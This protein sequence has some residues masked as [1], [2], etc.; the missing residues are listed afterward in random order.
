[1]AILAGEICFLV[2]GRGPLEY[3]CDMTPGAH[4]GF[5]EAARL[6]LRC[7]CPGESEEE[8]QP[9]LPDQPVSSH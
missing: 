7:G 6:R 8:Y 4:T 3:L 2:A 5:P 1:M 9:H